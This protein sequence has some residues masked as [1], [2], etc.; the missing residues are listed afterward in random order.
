MLSINLF[1]L[2]K[3]Q[4]ISNPVNIP[5]WPCLPIKIA[6]YYDKLLDL[7]VLCLFKSADLYHNKVILGYEN[8]YK[9]NGSQNLFLA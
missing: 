4:K 5:L 8:I 9:E 2:L 6:F 3:I 1:N 7:I